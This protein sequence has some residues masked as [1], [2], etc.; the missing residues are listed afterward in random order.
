MHR[1][2]LLLTITLIAITTLSSAQDAENVEMVGRIY[3]LWDYAQDVV[4]V[5]DLAY[6]S[7][8]SSGLQ[9]VDVSDQGNPVVVG[10]VDDIHVNTKVAISG[11][12]AYAPAG[13]RGLC[14]ISISDPT[15]P[16]VIGYFETS[17]L[18][19]V[20]TISGNYCY[21]AGRFNLS[22]VTIADP[23]NLEE[24]GYIETLTNS[25]D[26]LV[27]EELLILLDD[28][29]LQLFSIADPENPEAQ[30]YIENYA[31]Q[32]LRIAVAG[33]F[34][35]ISSG[36]DCLTIISIEDPEHPEVAG[37][38]WA[39]NWMDDV[40]I[41]GEY[42]CITDR[43]SGF[44]IF[45]FAD[46]ENPVEVGH[47][48]IGEPSLGFT[49]L[50][51]SAFV[52]N[53]SNGMTV[54]SLTDPENPEEMGTYISHGNAVGVTLSGEYAYVAMGAAGLSVVST[55]DPDNPVEVGRIDTDGYAE[56]IAISGDYAYVADGR[57]GL[58]VISIADPENLEEVGR[59]EVPI[60]RYASDVVVSQDYAYLADG[61]GLLVI[62]ISDPES[63][64]RISYYVPRNYGYTNCAAVLG[65]FVL[66][67]EYSVWIPD[68]PHDREQGGGLRMISVADPENPVELGYYTYWRAIRDLEV[69]DG[70]IYLISPS[71]LLINT[72]TEDGIGRRVSEYR[73]Q[74]WSVYGVAISDGYAFI[75][76]HNRG[77]RVLSLEDHAHPEEVGY[78]DTNGLAN[79]ATVSDDGLIYVADATNLGIY[80][81]TPESVS[82]D[83][84]NLAGNFT[85]FASYP[86]PFNSTP[87]ITYQLPTESHLDLALYD[88][89]GRQVMT[90]LSGVRQAGVWSTTL[91]GSNLSSGVYFVKLTAGEVL[92]SEKVVLIK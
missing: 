13:D 50:G 54:I 92:M 34:A 11:E 88:I 26:I 8:G 90:L 79:N 33:D 23:N 55:R 80:R 61:K 68:A 71:G 14:I 2:I 49:I 44:Y 58:C 25:C 91:N 27:D 16:E 74:A 48:Q 4:V 51:N 78:F 76:Q 64:E 73:M 72:I 41:F 47:C 40:E 39:F 62:S 7:T 53:G 3:N 57:N 6:V 46:Y 12:I 87:N 67:G 45:E 36:I 22:I 59:L 20:I 63:P 1:I 56:C 65:H 89:S 15:N 32:G 66:V 38:F 5:D 17:A 18:A 86:N 10:F 82:D 37:Y 52:T 75:A 69:A 43:D 28:E 19:G 70:Y 24:V 83:P 35:Y 9:I 42:V 30:G 84:S 29:E 85:L 31:L 77:L 81:F 60:H 21:V